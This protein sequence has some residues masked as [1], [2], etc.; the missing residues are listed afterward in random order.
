VRTRRR[1]GPSTRVYVHLRR[2]RPWDVYYADWLPRT[3]LE[4]YAVVDGGVRRKQL[5]G[6]PGLRANPSEG[7]PKPIWKA[8]LSAG[9][10][11]LAALAGRV[12]RRD[13]TPGPD[14]RSTV[15][16]KV[17]TGLTRKAE[18]NRS[19]F[20]AGPVGGKD[21]AGDDKLRRFRFGTALA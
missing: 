2:H 13:S 20:R 1:R 19:W 8:R 15:R 21:R 16:A 18:P 5:R 17:E 3:S 9:P 4:N 10:A 6:P 7:I 14:A 12:G 11:A